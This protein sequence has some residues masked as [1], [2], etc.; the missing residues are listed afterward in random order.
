MKVLKALNEERA[1]R[2]LFGK[3]SNRLKD[4]EMILRFFAFYYYAA[5]YNRPMKDFLNR[6]M[7]SNRNLERQT[8]AELQEVFRT[9]S[10][11][12]GGR[13]GSACIQARESC[14]RCC[15]GLLDDRC[16]KAPEKRSDRES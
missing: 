2:N 15:R 6:Y 8:E 14:E 12:S 16:R 5:Q 1:W 13:S 3:K 4:M 10:F 9:T 7:A 11:G